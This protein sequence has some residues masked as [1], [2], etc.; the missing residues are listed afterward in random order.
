MVRRRPIPVP[1]GLALAVVTAALAAGGPAAAVPAAADTAYPAAVAPATPVL[2]LRRVSDLVTAMVGDR[3]LA[4][5]LGPAMNDTGGPPGQACLSVRNPDGRTVFARNT[6]VALI[7]AS[8][9]KLETATA[10]MARLGSGSHLTTEVRAAAAPS[11]GTVA[12][13]LWLVGGGDP[14]LATND[15]A[16]V[17]GYHG[18]PRLSSSME[19]LADRVVAAGIRRVDG[20]V[21]GDESRYDTQRYVPSW[22]PSYATLG[23][24]GPQ[25]ALTVNG[26]FV[27]W[28]PQAVPAPAPATNAAAVLTTLLEARGVTVAGEAGEGR[29]PPGP[30]LATLDSPVMAD[31]VRVMLQESDNLAAELLV[32]ELGVRFGASGTTMAGLAV[33][34]DSLA[35]LA[36]PVEG[37]ASAD[38]SGL[39][40]SDRL[41]CDSLQATL[42]HSGEGGDLGRGMPVAGRDGTLARRFTGTAAA[43]KIKAKTGSLQGVT[44]LSG[45]ATARDGRPMQFALLANDLPRD[46]AGTALQDR[47]VAALAAW[48][49][50][51]SPEEISP[52]PAQPR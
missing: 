15:F 50:A 14:L 8:T 44:G 32:K 7:P 10:A 1:L 16:Q 3:R 39:D 5:Q 30:T 47:V 40:R 17:A 45:W 20:R 13:D 26:G 11:G 28:R 23:E 6:T 27:Q 35:S 9:M 52:L 18:Q 43:G 36:L 33:V 31:V 22:N 37:L 48:P 51:P 21:V 42:A 46:A 34:K 4:A 12:G 25:S 38:G 2:S 41:T 29:S 24:I 19:A 49:Q